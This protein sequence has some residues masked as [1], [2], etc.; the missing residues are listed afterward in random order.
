[1]CQRTAIVVDTWGLVSWDPLNPGWKMPQK[2]CVE[3][4][5]KFPCS[6]VV[7][8]PRAQVPSLMGEPRSQKL[9]GGGKRRKIAKIV[10]HQFL[11]L[12]VVGHSW[13]INSLKLCSWLH[14]PWSKTHFSEQGMTTGREMQM[15]SSH[16]GTYCSVPKS[17]LTVCDPV[18]VRL[19]FPTLSPRICSNSCLWIVGFRDMTR[20]LPVSTTHLK[21]TCPKLNSRS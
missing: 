15:L 12:T 9:C 1:M 4:Q 20:S 11:Y 16:T 19:S 21:S 3:K 8:T 14:V 2:W 10:I 5:E 6:P 13:D 18:D 7:R 17:C